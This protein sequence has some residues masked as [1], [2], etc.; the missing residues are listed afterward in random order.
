M[1]VLDAY[2]SDAIPLR[3]LTCEAVRLYLDRLQRDGWLIF[4][5]SNW[6]FKLEP[7]IVAL[8]RDAG[9]ACRVQVQET[10][11]PENKMRGVF[12]SNWAVMAREEA[13]LG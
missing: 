13:H 6:Y 12:A 3:L 7:V 8:A 1:L 2:S 5:F 4:H 9:L 10:V 11:G